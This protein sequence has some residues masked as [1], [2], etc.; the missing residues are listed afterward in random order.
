M[1]MK[2]WKLKVE[3]IVMKVNNRE[4]QVKVVN[5]IDQ[6]KDGDKKDLEKYHGKSYEDAESRYL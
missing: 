4:W 3:V 1:I 6:V 2:K 5:V